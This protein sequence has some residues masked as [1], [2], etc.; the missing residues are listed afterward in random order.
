MRAAP[1]GGPS[2]NRI[3]ACRRI[4]RQHEHVAVLQVAPGAVLSREEIIALLDQRNTA[5]RPQH[6]V[7]GLAHG[8]ASSAGRS[9]VMRM[10]ASG[11][12]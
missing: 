6:E 12:L 10:P 4:L 3:A 1:T 8:V 11:I 5:Q 9:P 7:R 2:A